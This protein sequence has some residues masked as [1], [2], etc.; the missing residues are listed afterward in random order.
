MSQKY[1]NEQR[2]ARR[3]KVLQADAEVDRPFA[4]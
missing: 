1:Q 4:G 2:E 3:H